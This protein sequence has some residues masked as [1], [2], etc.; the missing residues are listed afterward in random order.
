MT[1]FADH[2]LPVGVSILRAFSSAA[3][4]RADIPASSARI[5]AIPRARARASARPVV[6][7]GQSRA[8]KLHATFLGC[9]K[10]GLGAVADVPAANGSS[11]PIFGPSYH[12]QTHANRDLLICEASPLPWPRLFLR[13]R[14]GS[15]R[16]GVLRRRFEQGCADCARLDAET[17]FVIAYQQGDRPGAPQAVPLLGR[18]FP[19]K[20]GLA[21]VLAGGAFLRVLRPCRQ[22]CS[23]G[24]PP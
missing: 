11:A 19:C 21:G 14:S 24:D 17:N 13:A 8:A 20:L 7:Y 18:C 16:R 12:A 1:V 5:G 22:A 4:D 15:P 9:R 2:G 23:P 10:A 3:T 6:D